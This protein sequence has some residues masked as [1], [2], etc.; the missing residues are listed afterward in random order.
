MSVRKRG[1]PPQGGSAGSRRRS[2]AGAGAKSFGRERPRVEEGRGPRSALPNR[3]PRRLAWAGG[4]LVATA[5][6]LALVLLVLYPSGRGPGPGNALEFVVD[7]GE[8]ADGLAEKLAAVGLVS[9]PRLFAFYVAVTG[10]AKDLVKGPH[11][12]TDDASPGDL[13]ARL[14]RRSGGG[15]AKVT[16]PEGWNRFD[17]AKRLQEKHVCTLR[18]F[19]EATGDAPLLKELLIDGD[20][21]EGYLFPATYD[22]AFDADA[23]DVVR[24]M[25]GE[26]DK[27]Y[28]TLAQ[29]HES[30]ILD[31]SM[32]L[33]FAARDIVIL[34]SIVEKE[35]AVDDERPIIASVFLN[36]LRDPEFTQ[37]RLLQS[38]PTAGYGCLLQ[39][40][41]PSCA[42]YAGK[43]T[44]AINSDPAN[45]YS[46]YKHEGLPAGP[47]ANPGA[48]SLEAVMAPANTR[49]FYFVAKGEGRHAFSETYAAHTAAIKDG[50]K[51]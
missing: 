46:T 43:I 31:L 11:L 24:R 22:L 25:K 9:S 45:P 29:R 27:R 33:K 30:G 41:L 12:L 1:S 49:Y 21:A 23:A 50:G 51:H 38:D 48:K 15:H 2:S 39:P 42:G 7:D 44:P 17:M 5:F 8:S 47:I 10:G 6:G 19:L 35:A 28:L 32:T 37:P 4:G 18:A 26:F 16:F 14:E 40:E 36:R 20:S 3:R 13:L 34:A